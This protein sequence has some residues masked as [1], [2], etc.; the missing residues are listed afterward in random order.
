M[1]KEYNNF[2]NHDNGFPLK[3]N[4]LCRPNRAGKNSSHN[5]GFPFYNALL[6]CNLT[7][8]LVVVRFTRQVTLCQVT[9]CGPNN[10]LNVT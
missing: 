3:T 1:L 7:G 6:E 10:S 9:C 2:H 4:P 8:L 5:N